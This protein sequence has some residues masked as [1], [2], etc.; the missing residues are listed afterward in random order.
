MKAEEGDSKH[1]R[2]KMAQT[3]GRQAERKQKARSEGQQGLWF[4]FGMF[5]LIG[6]AV[7]VPTL[8]GIALGSWLDSRWPGEFSWTITLLFT[9]IIIGCINAW[10]W[11]KRESH[12]D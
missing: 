6:W 1:A 2:S 4:G 7:T 5:G 12:R 8:L 3:V 11:V 9:G 10:W